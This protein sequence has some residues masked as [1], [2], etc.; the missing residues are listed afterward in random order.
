MANEKMTT[1]P[2]DAV[3]RAYR[4]AI[5]DAAQT[6][7]KQLRA[8]YGAGWSL[9]GQTAQENAV[10]M[11]VLANVMSQVRG[12]VDVEYV[13]DMYRAVGGAMGVLS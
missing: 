9:L 4:A 1:E 7:V 6:Y 2:T 10:A 3:A 5:K 12:E 13:R 8:K 11:V